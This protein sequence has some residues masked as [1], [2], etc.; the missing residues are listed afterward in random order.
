MSDRK[1][2]VLIYLAIGLVIAIAVVAM[3][4]SSDVSLAFLLCDGCF[5][6]GVLVMGMGGLKFFRNQGVFDAMAYSIAYVFYTAFP[7]AKPRRADGVEKE[8]L[9]EYKE[10]KRA[11]RKPAAELLIAGAVYLGLAAIALV[12]Y[13]LT[14]N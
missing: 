3:E 2:G 12:I 6:A 4:W 5:V 13:L 7:G 1:K 10:R 8:K 9:Y 11:E 14:E